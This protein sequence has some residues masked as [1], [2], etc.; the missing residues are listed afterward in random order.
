MAVEVAGYNVNSFYLLDEPA[1][2]QAEVVCDGAVLASTAGQGAAFEATI[3]KHR[4]Q[5]VQRYSFQRPFIEYYRLQRRRRSVVE[6]VACGRPTR[7][8]ARCRLR[9]SS[10]SGAWRIPGS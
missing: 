8:P 3:L 2:L 6:S 1:F 5:K 9:E 4:V 7:R 10:S